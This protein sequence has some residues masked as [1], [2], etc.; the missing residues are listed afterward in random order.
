MFRQMDKET[1][2]TLVRELHSLDENKDENI[3]RLLEI[4]KQLYFVLI[5]QEKITEK[6]QL[7]N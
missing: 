3:P 6:P 5:W 4:C 7:P 1:Y 2:N